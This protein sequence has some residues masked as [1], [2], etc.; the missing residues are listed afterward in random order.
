M[1]KIAIVGLG[2]MGQMHAQV[3]TQLCDAEL[4]AIVDA[5]VEGAT[6]KAKDAGVEA[7]IYP[8]LEEALNRHPEITVVDICLPTSQHREFALKAIGAGKNVFCEKPLALNAC[9]ADEIVEAARA[10]NVALQVGHVVRFFPESRAFAEFL[11][12]NRAGKL[13]SLNLTRRAG[14]PGYSKDNWLSDPAKSL[15]AIFD[16]HIHDTDFVHHLLGTPKAVTS[17]GTKDAG[18]WTHVFTHYH[19]DDVIVRA[20]GGWNYPVNWGFRATFEAVFENGTVEYDTAATPTLRLTLGDAAPE[21]MEFEP[22]SAGKSQ[23]ENGNISSLAGYYDE[24]EAFIE[25][26]ERGEKPV[27]ATGEQAARSVR[28]ALA[29]IESVETGRTISL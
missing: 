5:D 12:S 23:A 13:L 26:L 6:R 3:Y 10:K 2:F 11:K 4:T 27:I 17:Y 16:L 21:P 7:P 20:E 9:D 28:T 19:F 29:E 14:R 25:S 24:L 1:Q 15:G 18:G 22:S 8:S